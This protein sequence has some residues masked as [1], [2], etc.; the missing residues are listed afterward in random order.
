MS[1][2]TKINLSMEDTTPVVCEKCENNAFVPLFYFRKA[3][4]ILTGAPKDTLIPIQ[5][6]ACSSC[7]HMNEDFIP[8]ELK[9]VI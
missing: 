8:Q 1:Q 2:Q 9:G 5:V 3:S 7:G 4:K 6:F